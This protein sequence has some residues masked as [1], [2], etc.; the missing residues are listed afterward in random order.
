MDIATPVGAF[1]DHVDGGAG[2]GSGGVFWGADGLVGLRF[3]GQF[4]NYG[5]ERH[6]MPLSPTLPYVDVDLR[7]TNS[8]F[9]GGLGPQ[10]F[11]AQGPIRPYVYGTAGF[12]YFVTYTRVHATNRGESIASTHNFGDFRWA[13]AGGGGLSLRIR[14]GAKP[15]SLDMSASY[16][17]H[18][19]TEY[20]AGGA[21]NLRQL[22]RGEWVAEYL[23][24]GG[25]ELR[26]LTR[27]NWVADPIVSDANFMSYR[28]GVSF[29][30]G[31][32]QTSGADSRGG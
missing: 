5:G 1:K 31:G 29:G 9:S 16:R 10:I 13:L 32:G 30:F 25:A 4:I 6:R 17:R 19:M 7:T 18:G 20:L 11:L 22:T 8:I 28:I 15:I 12:A 2:A 27:G 21:E 14:G 3:E 24:G 26:R 23:A